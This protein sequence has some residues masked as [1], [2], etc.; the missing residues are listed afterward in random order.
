MA[1][2]KRMNLASSQANKL[3]G[4]ILRTYKGFPQ[5]NHAIKIGEASESGELDAKKIKQLHWLYVCARCD[6]CSDSADKALLHFK[7]CYPT[8]ESLFES[9]V[10]KYRQ[11]FYGR[12]K[13]PL[14]PRKYVSNGGWTIHV[15]HQHQGYRQLFSHTGNLEDKLKCTNCNRKFGFPE[16]FH[17]H[18][19]QGVECIN[20]PINEE[21]M[22]LLTAN[23][24]IS[25][26][27]AS[28]AADAMVSPPSFSSSD[29]D[30]TKKI[31]HKGA[32]LAAAAVVNKKEDK[33]TTAKPAK[34]QPVIPTPTPPRSARIAKR[35]SALL[36]AKVLNDQEDS[37]DEKDRVPVKRRA[38]TAVA[39]AA[40]AA[41]SQREVPPADCP[42]CGESVANISQHLAIDHKD[43]DLSVERISEE[44]LKCCR[45]RMTFGIP[46]LFGHPG[47]CRKASQKG[48]DEEANVSTPVETPKSSNK[49]EKTVHEPIEIPA[50]VG[51][52]SIDEMEYSLD[53]LMTKE[54]LE[55]ALKCPVCKK[56]GGRMGDISICLKQHGIMRCSLCFNTYSQREHYDQHMK[57]CH[58]ATGSRAKCLY[59]PD[60]TFTNIGQCVGHLHNFH[61]GEVLQKPKRGGKAAAKTNKQARGVEKAES[62]GVLTPG[63]GSKNDTESIEDNS[64]QSKGDDVPETTEELGR[65]DEK[66][67]DGIELDQ[68]EEAP[69]DV[70]DS[71][72]VTT[73]DTSHD[74]DDSK[75][76]DVSQ[77]DDEND[78]D[79]KERDDDDADAIMGEIKSATPPPPP[80]ETLVM[81]KKSVVAPL[82]D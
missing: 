2:L 60:K 21:S 63:E 65:T 76:E 74:D 22:P 16:E 62:E 61:W 17:F 30:R 6:N 7:K 52:S 77:I 14:C 55:K 28:E 47:I 78:N 64:A 67:D 44:D 68:D 12:T 54:V 66:D 50:G 37:D 51:S 57:K 45:C 81:A 1:Q 26:A 31:Q 3:S 5:A 29:N 43:M 11:G 48:K 34:P 10:T 75:T 72:T 39:A 73:T 33:N 25:R 38:S 4:K 41:V 27:E 20:N 79:E 71:T 82:I 69:M 70:T 36:M 80:G 40:T 8:G 46:D 18:L 19:H 13:C 24:S 32:V 42:F 23:R 58:Y 53:E 49:R 59:C 9:T 35:A 15:G 56:Q